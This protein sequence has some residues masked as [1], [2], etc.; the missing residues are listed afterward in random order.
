MNK[1]YYFKN[2]YLFSSATLLLIMLL[3]NNVSAYT[4]QNL[5][6]TTHTQNIPS[7]NN[8]IEFIWEQAA[9]NE[10]DELYGYYTHF[11]TE[12][13][14]SFSSEN[15]FDYD[16]I[17]NNQISIISDSESDDRF[18]YFYIAVEYYDYTLSEDIIGTTLSLGP[19]RIDVIPPQQVSVKVP[20]TTLTREISLVLT[21]FD[22]SH[23]PYGL[24]NPDKMYI[25]ESG[26]GM[27]GFW[28]DFSSERQWVLSEGSGDKIIY[29]Q[30]KDQAENISYAST[31][32]KKISEQEYA[33]TAVAGQNGNID[34]SGI[35]MVGDG[36]DQTFSIM[37]DPEYIIDDVFVD[38]NS[39]GVLSSYTFRGISETHSITAVFA[40]EIVYTIT[41]NTGQYGIITP[42]G[43]IIV[44]PDENLSF[45]I[46]VDSG[47]EID[48]ILFN[49]QEQEL[50]N[51]INLTN[52][53]SSYNISV[54]FKEIKFT[55]LDV[56]RDGLAKALTD[57]LLIRTYMYW[58][59]N[60]GDLNL[61]NAIS[62]NAKRNQNDIIKYIQD[63]IDQKLLDIDKDNQCLY[64]TDGL[65]IMRYL[66]SLNQG[67]SLTKNA[68]GELSSL[69]TEEI[70]ENIKNILP[71]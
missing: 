5:H 26:F 69:S 10:N 37:P 41:A 39:I 21:G 30:F 63:G 29:V 27:S 68:I 8:T 45:T 34:P 47:Y 36:E 24:I 59:S 61:T 66:F 20:E 46:S 15:I 25:S 16:S 38:G 32:I 33:I 13:S 70:I 14:F 18:Y 6:S 48:Y 17:Q 3:I 2:S 42:T 62:Q 9:M 23:R 43:T 65:L 49:N 31:T 50:S 54:T 52:I 1:L 35:V 44:K 51:Y 71:Q 22:G 57:G 12:S 60:P 67:L 58:L 56:D 11:T 64:D 19:Y 40:K 55:N 7:Q 53:S 28:E 4:V